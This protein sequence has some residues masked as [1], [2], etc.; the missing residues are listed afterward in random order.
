MN[1]VTI[2]ILDDDAQ[3]LK[4]LVD[5]AEKSNCKV[6]GKNTKPKL[7]INE[8]ERLKPDIVILDIQMQPINGLE[9][10]LQ[11]P[12]TIRVMFCSSDVEMARSSYEQYFKDY[13]LKPFNYHSFYSVLK[14]TIATLPN[15]HHIGVPQ[16]NDNWAFY[17]FD[18]KGSFAKL[19]YDLLVYGSTAGDSKMVFNFSNGGSRVINKRIGEIMK[20]LP[21]GRFARISKDMFVCLDAIKEIKS[22]KLIIECGN[23]EKSLEIG[24]VYC[25][26]IYKWVE[27]NRIW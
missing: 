18:V 1:K 3:D 25:N 9:V 10:L 16:Q 5:F 4:K 21:P 19:D 12:D 24:D 7:A 6:I 20:V 17:G 2:Y 22:G 23:E 27:E 13:L 11:L 8:I 26:D 14:R 15:R